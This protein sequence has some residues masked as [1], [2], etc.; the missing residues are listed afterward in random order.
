MDHW[1]SRSASS[2]VQ[3]VQRPTSEGESFAVV[4]T[5][6]LHGLVILIGL[7]AGTVLGGVT[8]ALLAVS[9]IAADSGI[10]QVWNGE[11]APPPWRQKRH[12]TVP[13]C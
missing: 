9:L 4:R 2:P 1:T 7:T 8:G 13:M 11:D 6:S 5:H 3:E 10:V 12:E